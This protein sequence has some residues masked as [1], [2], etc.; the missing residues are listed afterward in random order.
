V[1]FSEVTSVKNLTKD[2]A[3]VVARV[4]VS[5]QEDIDRVVEILRRVCDELAEDDELGPLIL[6]RFDYLGVDSLNEFSVVLLL[7]VRTLPAKQWVVGRAL[8]RGIKIAFDAHG[9][10]MRD[11]SPV[12]IAGPT[13]AAL[14]N[15]PP[16][17]PAP[18]AGADEGPGSSAALRR[19][20]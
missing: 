16:G 15:R 5:Y 8:N 3:F 17:E 4:A 13:L 2:F 6:D 11:P 9:I 18:T 1:P 19:T 10:A 14:A 12:K 7:R 20:G